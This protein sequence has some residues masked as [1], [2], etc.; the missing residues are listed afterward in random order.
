LGLTY[1]DKTSILKDSQSYDLIKK[2]KIKNINKLN[3]YD[4]NM[5]PSKDYL[6]KN[7]LVY[8]KK[9]KKFIN[10]SK[11]LLLMYPAKYFMNELLKSKN[12]IIIDCWNIVD[13]KKTTS[14]V[15]KLGKH[16]S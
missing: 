6:Q 10:N 12:K 2:L 13:E 14:K 3:V 1:K 15:Y 8:F 7:K 5:S 11:I 4:N 16:I 9:L